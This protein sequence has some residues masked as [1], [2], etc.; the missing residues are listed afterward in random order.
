M[1]SRKSKM[2]KLDSLLNLSLIFVRCADE[3]MKNIGINFVFPTIEKL[4]FMVAF[5]LL[6]SF[7]RL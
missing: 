4:S 6:F 1:N 2:E 7:F 5:M 3:G